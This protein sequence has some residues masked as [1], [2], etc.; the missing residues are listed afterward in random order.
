MLPG[1]IDVVVGT[2]CGG[3]RPFGK[4]NEQT[5][6]EMITVESRHSH[7]PTHLPRSWASASQNRG[8]LFWVEGESEGGLSDEKAKESKYTKW[9]EKGRGKGDRSKTSI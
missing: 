8:G 4:A 1:S 9:A 6:T 2:D 7:P 3:V 5:H